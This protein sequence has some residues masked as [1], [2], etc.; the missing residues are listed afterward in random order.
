[1]GTHSSELRPDLAA[2]ASAWF[3]EFRCDDAIP[4]VRARFEKWLRRSP[5]H[6]EA[7]L[8]VAAGWSELPTS[9]PEHRIDIQALVAAARNSA[10]ENVI[11]FE[12]VSHTHQATRR[13]ARRRILMASLASIAAAIGLTVWL[14]PLHK[15]TYSTSIGEQR[16]LVLADGSTVILN[17]RTTIKVHMTKRVREIS[18]LRGQ[19]F[20][21]DV[22]EPDRSFI[23]RSGKT[24]VRA[25][26]T[27]FDINKKP[28]GMVVTVVQGRVAVAEPPI[29][30]YAKVPPV[31]TKGRISSP[32]LHVQPVLA[33]A[34]EQVTVLAQNIELPRHV[35]V[36]TAIAWVHKRLVFDNTPF[37]EVARQFNL[38]STRRMV[39]ADP[40]LK[41]LRISGVYSSADPQALID[42][43][44]AQHTL[45]VTETPDEIL[46]TRSHK[47]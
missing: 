1:M 34:G 42:F 47:R 29:Q 45:H 16:T 8:E 5:E 12:Q 46:V 35:D 44:R 40:S 22:D 41:K 19:A 11:P 38:Y 32:V 31:R 37:V 13:Y 15:N 18:L 20:F 6:I 23:V 10:D 3:I 33:T 26:G 36:S 30:S 39:I 43:L 27:Q 21:H 25:L 4:A 7:Y 14:F 17:A 2:E 9:D 28:K 24:T